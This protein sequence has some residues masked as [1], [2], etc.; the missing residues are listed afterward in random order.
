MEIKNWNIFERFAHFSNKTPEKR[1]LSINGENVS[2]KE[3]TSDVHSLTA[4]LLMLGVN[5]NDKIGIVLQNSAL[6]YKLFWAIVNAGAH[7]VPL[8]PQTGEWELRHTLTTTEIKYCFIAQ[9]YRANMI[10]EHFRK[11]YKQSHLV[12]IIVTEPSEENEVFLNF[13]TFNNLAGKKTDTTI[14]NVQYTDTLSYVCTSG[15]TGNPK[16]I[17]VEHGGFY[18]AMD[19]MAGYLTLTSEDKML[20]GMP[21]Y[22]QGGFGMGVQALMK[23][24]TVFY[25]TQFNPVEFLELIDKEKVT[26]LQLTA[27]LA[28][29]LLTV[30]DFVNYDLSSLKMCYFAG[31]VLPDE[32]AKQF[33]MHLK[34]R[35]VNVIGSSET[36]TMVVWD[37][38][39]D[40]D[41]DVN[42]FRTLPFTSM[43][44]INDAGYIVNAGDAGNI[45]IQTDAVLKEYY[46]NKEETEKKIM[47]IGDE[48]WF[49]TGDL[50]MLREDGRVKLI[51][52]VK[53][54]I[55]RGAN[56]VYPEEIEAYLLTHPDINAVAV[57]KEEQELYG[58]MIIAYV[59]VV[60]GKTLT[61]GDQL[62]FCKG[63]LSAYKIPDKF[64]IV[65]EIPNDIG[66]VQ[67]KYLR[68]KVKER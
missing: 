26:V 5:K 51:G 11:V 52:R 33:F 23:G 4:S 19:D 31:E 22:H 25:Q 18:K 35:V 1:I 14:C 15:T 45:Y 16:I 3:F 61:R 47:Y 59:Q 10:E 64:V 53:R 36:G 13:D 40:T 48:R 54:V 58:E 9:R 55:K 30:P 38:L 7:P 32:I 63:Q 12:K 2:Y 46:K 66:K 39:Y 49:N 44:I 37:S 42:C 60:K 21:L 67:Y 34:I 8:D 50:G 28:K 62:K 43:K 57:M 20:L 56:L 41:V 68:E 29:I 27:T 17:N 6:W 65:D 24:G